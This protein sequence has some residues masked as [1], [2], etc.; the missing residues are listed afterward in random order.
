VLRPSRLAGY[1][2]WVAFHPIARLRHKV[3]VKA[4]LPE[5]HSRLDNQHNR[6]LDLRRSLED[7]VKNLEYRA[8][9]DEIRLRMHLDSCLATV[10]S[11]LTEGLATAENRLLSLNEALVAHISLSSANDL[12]AAENRL[13]SLNERLVA[14]IS[15]VREDLT[16]ESNMSFERI[17]ADLLG[18][19][20]ALDNI[21]HSIDS[22]STPHASSPSDR[23]SAV[24]RISD[25]AYIELEDAFRGTSELI[26]SRQSV[27]LPLIEQTPGSGPV[28][29]IGCGRGEWL[30]LL[31]DSG[32]H[33]YGIDTNVTAVAECNDIGLDVGCTD[34]IEHLQSVEHGSLRAITAFQ[35]LEHLPFASLFEV[36][37]L[38]RRAL[39]NGGVFIAEVPNA[40]N[41]RVASGTF[42]I[43]PTHERPWYPDLLEYIAHSAGFSHVEG[44][45]QNPLIDLPDLSDLDDNARRAVT[46]VFE[47]VFGAADFALIATV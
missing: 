38:A 9:A 2:L 10:R 30:S 35:V 15:Q 11:E 43:D 33:A 40:K 17:G 31:R 5:I 47:A 22:A 3:A 1:S 23:S 21:R 39:A 42:W 20:R 28:L 27:Y 12:A 16:V 41:A 18:I 8:I 7:A 13:L 29:D 6:L 19:R 34:L 26:K 45:Y 24:E 14:H 25:L 46:L 36:V 4:R 32:I 37:R 44:L